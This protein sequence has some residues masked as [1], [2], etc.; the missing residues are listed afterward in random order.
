MTKPISQDVEM[1]LE[2]LDLSDLDSRAALVVTWL[3]ELLS[4]DADLRPDDPAV[5]RLTRTL[6]S[7]L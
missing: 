3:S 7:T 5:I 4:S 1:D 2:I 6:V